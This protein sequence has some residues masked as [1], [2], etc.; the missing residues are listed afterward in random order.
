[1]K[2][3]RQGDLLFIPE[4]IPGYVLE[5]E[6]D[7]KGVIAEG[8]ATGHHHRVAIL[9]DA[10]VYRVHDDAYLN[11]GPNG[12]SIVHEEHHSVRLEPNT[13]YKVNRAR[14]FDYLASMARYIAD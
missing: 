4:V 8:E 11:V 1:M 5:H 2:T 14:E 9:E 12:V 10:Q 7:K 3:I 6:P 13:T